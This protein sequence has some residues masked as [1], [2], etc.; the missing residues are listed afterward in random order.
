[1]DTMHILVPIDFSPHAEA[2]LADAIRFA[3]PFH[4]HVTLL[5]VV[6]LPS[7]VHEGLDPYHI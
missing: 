7:V 5:H 2:A 6:D 4:A 3:Q 1:M